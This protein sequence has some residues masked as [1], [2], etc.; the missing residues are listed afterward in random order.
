MRLSGSG[1]IL[2]VLIAT[3]AAV[4]WLPAEASET[5][6]CESTSRQV[7]HCPVDTSGGVS[8]ETQYSRAGC[9]QGSTWGYDAH[10][11]WVSNGCRAEFHV[12]N[13]AHAHGSKS[14]DSAAAALAAAALI[15]VVAVA[16]ASDD[17]SSSKHKNQQYQDMA[18]KEWRRSGGDQYGTYAGNNQYDRYGSYGNYGRPHDIVRCESFGSGRTRCPAMTSRAHVEIQRKLS[19]ASCRYGEDWNYD[20][21]AIYVYNGC[22]ADFRVEP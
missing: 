15:G 5:I 8:L 20:N 16:A 1:R 7:R 6:T 22:R 21:H 12:G 10:S 19:N 3:A 2:S 14:N 4:S 18:N 11:I 13:P 9:Y 17:H